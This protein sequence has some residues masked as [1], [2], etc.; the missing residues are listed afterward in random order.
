MFSR[1]IDKYNPFKTR[2]VQTVQ[3][4]NPAHNAPAKITSFMKRTTTKRRSHYLKTVCSDSGVCIAFG[5]ENTKLM[6]FFRFNTFIFAS[7]QLRSIGEPSKNGFVK[8]VHYERFGYSAD[9]IL[10]STIKASSDNLVY[11]YIVGQTVNQFAYYYPVFIETYGIFRYDSMIARDLVKTDKPV[12][13]SKRLIRMNPNDVGSVCKYSNTECLLIQHLKG[14]ETLCEMATDPSFFVK[15]SLYT[16]YL[17]YFT[18]AKLHESFTHYDLYCGNVLLYEPKKGH[19]IEY[20]IHSETPILFK[21]KYIPK[22]IDYGRSFVPASKDYY[23]Q[24]CSNVDC[25]KC[26]DQNGFNFFTKDTSEEELN[27]FINSLHK[28]ESHDLRLLHSFSDF[29]EPYLDSDDSLVH[30]F[31]RLVDDVVYEDY[32]GTPESMIKMKEINNVTQA[33]IRLRDLVLNPM[34]QLQNDKDYQSSVKMGELHIYTNGD[35]MKFIQST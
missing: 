29:C 31:I 3:T 33:E 16:F 1:M 26:G 7:H 22:I 35:P 2:R 13:L 32:F 12:D 8:E 14:A 25:P 21:S 17:I 15:D 11:E 9:A 28:N 4:V 5:K 27:Y 24:V 6:N 10:K 20:H 19:H 18:L 34:R 23:D 30:D